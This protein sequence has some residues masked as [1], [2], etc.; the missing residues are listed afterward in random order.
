MAKSPDIQGVPFT[1]HIMH[2]DSYINQVKAKADVKKFDFIH[3]I[4]VFRLRLPRT[5][6]ARSFQ[7][8]RCSSR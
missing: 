8:C 4:Q 2:S 6:E 5:P 7:T 1:W 3:S